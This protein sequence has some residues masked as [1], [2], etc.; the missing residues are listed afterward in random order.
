MLFLAHAKNTYTAKNQH[1]DTSKRQT[2]KSRKAAS[3]LVKDTSHP[4]CTIA[5]IGR[6]DK[7]LW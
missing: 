7:S 5:T 2:T 1:A 3:K 6:L 4:V